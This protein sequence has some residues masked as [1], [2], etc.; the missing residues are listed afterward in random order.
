MVI[1]IYFGR[2]SVMGNPPPYTPSEVEEHRYF[3]HTRLYDIIRSTPKA[4]FGQKGFTSVQNSYLKMRI[5]LDRYSDSDSPDSDSQIQIWMK[6][7]PFES[8]GKY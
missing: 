3:T 7:N 2:D 1:Y 6:P 4:N 8:L 5:F